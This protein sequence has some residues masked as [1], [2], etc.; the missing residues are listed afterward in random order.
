MS[1]PLFTLNQVT[2]VFQWGSQELR[3]LSGVNLE[4]QSGTITTIVGESGS[5]KST[6]LNMVGGLESIT[7]GTITFTGEHP[8]GED[9]ATFSD[10][11][12]TQYRRDHLGFIFQNPVL[13]SDFTVRENCYIPAYLAG[14]N[15]KELLERSEELLEEVGLAHRI[16]HYPGTLSGGEQQRLSIARALLH[17]PSIVLADEP[18]GSLDEELSLVMQDM[19]MNL[20]KRHGVTLLLV[21][22]NAELAKLGDQRVRLTHGQ[23]ELY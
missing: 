19:F 10:K 22:H 18:T 17:N 7:Q 1:N 2:K 3:I 15:K 21:T 13:L 20:V 12:L 6:L 23:V 14:G 9:I 11:K 5:G 4:L 16:N 8:A